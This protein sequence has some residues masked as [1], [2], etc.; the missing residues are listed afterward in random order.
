MMTETA[1]TTLMRPEDI[2]KL[3]QITRATELAWRSQGIL[4]PPIRMNRRVFYRRDDLA[5]IINEKSGNHGK[6]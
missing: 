5:R 1:F 2:H 3:F 4:P 6:R